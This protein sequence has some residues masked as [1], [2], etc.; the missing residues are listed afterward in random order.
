MTTQETV[1][2]HDTQAI[3]QQADHLVSNDNYL[4]LIQ[5][6]L[7]KNSEAGVYT[8]DKTY[9]VYG[10]LK[11]LNSKYTNAIF[12]NPGTSLERK[13]EEIKNNISDSTVVF[14]SDVSYYGL[15]EQGI[16]VDYVVTVDPGEKAS[17]F[18]DDNVEI[19]A[20]STS[21]L[22]L[23]FDKI[24]YA[25]LY[26]S[27]EETDGFRIGTVNIKTL[28]NDELLSYLVMSKKAEAV[29]N[30]HRDG[31][32]LRKYT[33]FLAR[34]TVAVTMYQIYQNL[35]LDA[36]FYGF[37]FCIQENKPYADFISKAN[38]EVFSK[39]PGFNLSLDEYNKKI[40]S[41]YYH[42]DMNVEAIEE[43]KF[44]NKDYGV[45]YCPPLLAVYKSLFI[46][47]VKLGKQN[48]KSLNFVI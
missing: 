12:I 14:C 6:N 5:N 4:K 25:Y 45:F 38:H 20:A 43:A 23:Y 3:E 19:I 9:S 44:E 1:T 21:P 28:S 27:L 47:Y 46:N 10:L 26:N 11:E 29:L 48:T 35:K 31:G 36:S 42:D 13:L 41:S 15:K 34:G 17:Y 7:E 39:I 16:R 30:I 32:V 18:V 8:S 37:D 24:K 22:F 40:I 2:I 33:E